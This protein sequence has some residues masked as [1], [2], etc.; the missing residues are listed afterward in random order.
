MNPLSTRRVYIILVYH[1]GIPVWR[2]KKLILGYIGPCV[3]WCYVPGA[4]CMSIL[5]VLVRVR[6][7]EENGIRI[8]IYKDIIRSTRTVEWD[9]DLVWNLE[10]KFM[11]RGEQLRRRQCNSESQSI[12][13]LTCTRTWYDFNFSTYSASASTSATSSPHLMSR[14]IRT[15]LIPRNIVTKPY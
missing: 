7:W 2:E 9:L 8:Q 15:Y 14:M 11:T 12:T 3:P 10:F 4:S 6:V 1:T 5:L 13:T